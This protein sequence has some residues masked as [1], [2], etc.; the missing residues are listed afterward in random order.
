MAACST[1]GGGKEIHFVPF[2]SRLS[3]AILLPQ[4]LPGI[5]KQSACHTQREA[6][7]L[8]DD[9]RGSKWQ[10][11][12]NNDPARKKNILSGYPAKMEAPF[13][14]HFFLLLLFPLLSPNFLRDNYLAPTMPF[15]MDATRHKTRPWHRRKWRL[16]IL[17]REPGKLDVGGVGRSFPSGD[18][19][20][21]HIPP[22]MKGK[23]A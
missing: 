23:P 14:I 12:S 20:R 4:P 19:E 22:D 17:E 6:T 7:S 9:E 11:R 10:T 18:P 13:R 8:G 16:A 1:G 15:A 2:S 3:A 5:N 21:L